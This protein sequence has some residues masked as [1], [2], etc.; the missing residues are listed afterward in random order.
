MKV[1]SENYITIQ[2]FMRTELHL[3][4][5]DL[6]VYAIIYGVSQDGES[7]FSGSLQYLADWCE[8]PTR[9]PTRTSSHTSRTER[10]SSSRT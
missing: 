1:Q 6:L 4:G 5:N 10:R 3:T 8:F 2:G 9:T 7:K